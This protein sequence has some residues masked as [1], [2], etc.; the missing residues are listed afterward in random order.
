M[1]V[2][3]AGERVKLTVPFS[4][5]SAVRETEFSLRQLAEDLKARSPI[6]SDKQLLAR[7]AYE[8]ARRYYVL[9]ALR[10]SELSEAE[11]LLDE[12]KRLC[13]GQAGQDGP[14]DEFDV[15]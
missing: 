6:S 3:I 15:L 2:N 10:E 5:Q 11:D 8:Y 14:V 7:M 4:R 9:K 13:G 1:E 12:A